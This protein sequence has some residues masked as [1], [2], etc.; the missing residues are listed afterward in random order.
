M[1]GSAV[2]RL[3]WPRLA[4]GYANRSNFLLG[5]WLWLS[6]ILGL[7]LTVDAPFSPHMTGMLPLLGI[8]PAL[9]V[10][11]GWRSAERLKSTIARPAFAAFAGA[12]VM[13]ALVANVRDYVQVHVVTMQPAGFATLLGRYIVDVN[14]AT[15]CT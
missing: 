2:R 7:I 11:A 8:Y 9:F 5:M 1:D 14:A 4:G 12:V 3:A 15:A 10:D 13:F 6:L